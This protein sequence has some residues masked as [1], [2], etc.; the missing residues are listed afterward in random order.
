MGTLR[1]RV[2]AEITGQLFPSCTTKEQLAFIASSSR[3]YSGST[4]VREEEVS[5]GAG[6]ESHASKDVVGE[7]GAGTGTRDGDQ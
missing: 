4:V 7:C 1:R 3:P 6:D 5:D 2:G